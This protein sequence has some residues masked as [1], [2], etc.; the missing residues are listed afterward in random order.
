MRRNNESEVIKYRGNYNK[1]Y[2]L[3]HN[4]IFDPEVDLSFIT[5]KIVLFGYLGENFF[6]MEHSLIDKFFTPLNTNYV[7]RSYPDMFGMVI[8]AN[9]V[10]MIINEDYIYDFSVF[11]NIVFSFFILYINS[12]LF[13]YIHKKYFNFYGGVSKLVMVIESVILL[14]VCLFIFH[15][16]KIQI[17]VKLSIIGLIFLPDIL[18]AYFRI[19]YKK[20]GVNL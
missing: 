17:D 18:E 11:L 13:Y 7:G 16:F 20:K 9:I 10:S 14:F 19:K 2:F 12:F 3:D 1:F 4:D 15:H 5:N 6:Q 8:H